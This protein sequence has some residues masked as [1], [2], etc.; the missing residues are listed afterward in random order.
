MLIESGNN[1]YK[2]SRLGGDYANCKAVHP[3]KKAVTTQAG[4]KMSSLSLH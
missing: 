4:R 2:S 3:L 1:E